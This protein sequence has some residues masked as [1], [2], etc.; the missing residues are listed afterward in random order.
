MPSFTHLLLPLE[1]S[2]A[3]VSEQDVIV[4]FVYVQTLYEVRRFRA[5][6]DSLPLSIHLSTRFAVI[7]VIVS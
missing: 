3:T 7:R 2:S 4:L 5:G 1:S 6:H